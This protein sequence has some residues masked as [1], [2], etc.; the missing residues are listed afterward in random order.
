MYNAPMQDCH[1]P[2]KFI[3]RLELLYGDRTQT[4][5]KAFETKLL[6][7]FRVNTLKTNREEIIN[8]LTSMEF[9]IEE[10]SWYKDAFILKNKS[11]R[12]LT[13]T[14]VYK[15]GLL[16]I[17]NLSSMV[18]AL[19]LDPQ[20][21]DK[22]LDI[23]AAPG[24]K[25]TQM[26]DLMSNKGEI[27][28]ND[29]SRKRIYRLK[30]NLEQYGVT[31]TKIENHA[32]ETFWKR[33]PEVFKK[34]LVDVPC[35]ME[36]RIQCDDP[37]SYEDW[38]PKKI[39]QLSMLQKYL[40]R[41]AISATD[42]GGTIVYSTCTLSPEENEEVIEWVVKRVN[43]ITPGAISL[44]R[45]KIP[46]LKLDPALTSWRNKPLHKAQNASRV[47]PNGTM[48]GFFIAKILKHKSTVPGM[49]IFH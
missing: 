20:P 33:Y 7:S 40:L 36:G 19:A 16:Y 38:S 10:V 47:T 34:T 23:A 6:P 21:G 5:L 28:A 44:E 30:N 13:E 39:K 15:N 24:S 9:E 46:G 1:L 43:D 18:P 27:V 41:S 2:E 48:E 32:G 26:A 49:E 25:T 11:T 42:V 22:I 17:Q 8:T 29:L 35:S 12:E 14:D 31:N 45:I 37:K 4:V 3:E